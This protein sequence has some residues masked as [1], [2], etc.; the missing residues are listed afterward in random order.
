MPTLRRV[1]STPGSRLDVLARRRPS[2]DIEVQRV[3]SEI[4]ERVESQGD[5]ALLDY[6]RKF[7]APDLSA[8]QVEPFELEGPDFPFLGHA[9]KRVREYHLHQRDVLLAGWRVAGDVWRWQKTDETIGQIMRPLSRVGIYVPGGRA[10]Y[11]SS[12]YM[13]VLPALVAGVQEI[14]VTTPAQPDGTLPEAVRFVLRSLGIEEVYKLGGASAIGALAFG[15]DSI[16]RV[17]K[18]VGPGNK[19]VNEAKRQVWG[20]VGL[21][22]YAGPS[23]VAVVIDESSDPARAAVDLL[24][25]IEHAPDNA[26]FLISLSEDAVVAVE[27]EIVI[28]L[29]NAPRAAILREALEKNSFAV[30]VNG[31]DEA[32]EW[33]NTIAPEHL[34]LAVEGAES[35]LEA[36]QN[37]GCVLIGEEGGE[38]MADYCIGASHTLPTSGAARFQSPLSVLEFMKIQSYAWLSSEDAHGIALLTSQIGELEGL[39]MH[40]Q[41]GRIRATF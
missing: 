29:A 35:W 22:G 25:Q 5:S 38:S 15:T 39:P 13:N 10:T 19:W 18:I 30:V 14:V 20:H 41:G 26:G 21:D 28:L 33:I 9:I 34:T 17:D 2:R 32:I 27:Q 11:P 3:V 8:I 40:A 23:E 16:R 37:A 12:V 1:L 4:L 24:T 31:K 36:I 7:D 6:A